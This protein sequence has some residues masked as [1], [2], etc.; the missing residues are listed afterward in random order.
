MH[1][2][3][4]LNA[5]TVC[6]I[7]KLGR[8][9]VHLLDQNGDVISLPPS[10]VGKKIENFFFAATIDH[11]GCE[12]SHGDRVRGVCDDQIEGMVLHSR[13]R[14]LFLQ[15]REH[16]KN[17][18]IFVVPSIKR[19]QIRTQGRPGVVQRNSLKENTAMGP[20]PVKA[21]NF[22]RFISAAVSA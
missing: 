18:G 22:K 11:N 10:Q 1:D 5:T 6:C 20:P 16:M 3:V 15:N 2:M 12:I 14:L 8:D 17:S 4:E 7:I 13:N 21:T 9:M 19:W